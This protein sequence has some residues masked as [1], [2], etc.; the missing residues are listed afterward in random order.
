MHT[1]PGQ[2]LLS[3]GHG[4]NIRTN[5]AQGTVAAGRIGL[6]EKPRHIIFTPSRPGKGL[7]KWQA[8]SLPCLKRIADAITHKKD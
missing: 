4:R 2:L 5:H 8:F 1:A 3:D 6:A 7:P